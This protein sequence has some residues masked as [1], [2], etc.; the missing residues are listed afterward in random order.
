MSY[1]NSKIGEPWRGYYLTAYGI[2]VKHG[3]RGTEEEWLASLTGAQGPQGNDGKSFQ[4]LGYYSDLSSLEAAVPSP[5]AGMAYGV[6]AA[7]PY[8]IYIFDGV[9]GTWVNNGPLQGPKGDTGDIGPQGEMGPRGLQGEKG[10][11]GE[12]GAQG[13]KGD[14]GATG[15][16]GPQGEKGDTGDAGPQGPQGETGAVG[17]Q[18]TPGEKGDTGATGPQGP[19]GEKGDTGDTGPQGPQGEKGDTGRG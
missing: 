10:D 5:A 1:G 2:A 13:P 12:T 19:Q 14:T 17:P 4:V 15:P 16:A 7:S 8:D 11:T 6:G 18:G 9:S 3:F